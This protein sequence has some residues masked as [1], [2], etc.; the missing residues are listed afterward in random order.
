M[1]METD[2]RTKVNMA[3]VSSEIRLRS[4]SASDT[5]VTA[6][7]SQHGRH[8][9]HLVSRFGIAP[10]RFV[11]GTAPRPSRQWD[12]MPSGPRARPLD[13]GPSSGRRTGFAGGGAYR[14][15]V[16]MTKT[17]HPLPPSTY[18]KFPNSRQE[19]RERIRV[20]EQGR[21]GTG[22]PT[23]TTYPNNN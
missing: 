19:R 2:P 6:V 10:T 13:Y 5:M 16:G 1:V 12:S 11:A 18:N 17:I 7:T 23:N 20:E 4:G 22:A 21:G 15:P 9:L 14:A 8:A 3:N